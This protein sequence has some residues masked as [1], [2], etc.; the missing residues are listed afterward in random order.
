MGK[1][2]HGEG[3][4]C[5]GSPGAWSRGCRKSFLGRA[6]GTV[7]IG[8][9]AGMGRQR[10]AASGGQGRD[11]LQGWKGPEGGEVRRA[12]LWPAPVPATW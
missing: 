2:R 1:L 10:G 11:P 6:R 8:R 7:G 4:T 3:G 12:W 9:V 5:C